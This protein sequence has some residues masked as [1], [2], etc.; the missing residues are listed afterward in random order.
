MNESQFK[1]N[2]RTRFEILST[3]FAKNLNNMMKIY[4]TP[5]MEKFQYKTTK[6]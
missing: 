1:E 3:N 5:K 2:S 6:K 4:S